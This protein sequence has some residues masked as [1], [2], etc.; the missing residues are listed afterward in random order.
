MASDK[1]E[2][3]SATV[4]SRQ[5]QHEA[6]AKAAGAQQALFSSLKNGVSMHKMS[7]SVSFAQLRSIMS[8][9]SGN[10]Q[11]TF[12]GTVDGSIVVSVNFNYE[13]PTAP[14]A[15]TKRKRARD[16]NEEAVQAAVDR[17]QKSLSSSDEVSDEM[18]E[19]AK[20]ALYTMLTRLRGASN[21]TAIESWGLSYKKPE[22]VSTNTNSRP[23][24]IL[25]LRLTPGVAV[26]LP[27]LFQCLGIRCTADGM[28]TTQESNSL[29]T[30]FNLPLSEAARAAETHGQRALTL[31]ATVNRS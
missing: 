3:S 2:S 28:L 16:S 12:V 27:S 22:H 21:E 31:F 11:R 6:L 30:G 4:P 26:P 17:V 8:A 1:K 29:A 15:P 20:A 24:L 18:L 10:E 25:S 7:Q 5:A 13:P 23:R 14:P 9:A 19:S